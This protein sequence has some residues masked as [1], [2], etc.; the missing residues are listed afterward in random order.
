MLLDALGLARVNLIG[1]DYGG[2]L[3]LGFVIRHPDRVKRFCLINSRAHRTFS[4]RIYPLFSSQCFAAR[5]RWLRWIFDCI[6]LGTIHRFLMRRFVARRSFDRALLDEYVG[7]LDTREGRRWVAYFFAHY[8]T[9]PRPELA[10]GLPGIRCPV[11]IIWGDRERHLPFST[12]EELAASIPGAR[13]HRIVGADHFV[14]E[15]RPGDVN[16]AL[17]SLLASSVAT[18]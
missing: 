13:L 10:R 15:E 4:R 16:D 14:M 17:R 18:A 11:A 6:P 8:D 3:G 5:R 9:V 2:F 12:A 1:H 7:W